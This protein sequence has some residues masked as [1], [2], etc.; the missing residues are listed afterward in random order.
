MKSALGLLAFWVLLA[1]SSVGYATG[2][3]EALEPKGDMGEV[4]VAGKA[5]IDV[6]KV[7]V[8]QRIA[9]CEIRIGN[10]VSPVG[11]PAGNVFAYLKKGET[12]DLLSAIPNDA[13]SVYTLKVKTPA[14]QTGYLTRDNLRLLKPYKKATKRIFVTPYEND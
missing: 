13:E 8:H 5:M 6:H 10:E 3:C 9:V 2:L 14:G 4:V 1:I 7:A 11:Y 12:V